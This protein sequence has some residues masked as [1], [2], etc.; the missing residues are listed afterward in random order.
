QTHTHEPSNPRTHFWSNLKPL[1]LGLKP[2]NL[3]RSA[4]KWRNR[5]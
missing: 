5:P 3:G 4:Y 1:E 2:T